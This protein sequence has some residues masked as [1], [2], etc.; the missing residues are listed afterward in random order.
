MRA[1]R[2]LLD[3]H[4]PSIEHGWCWRD[5]W[6]TGFD[7]AFGLL[8]KFAS[9]NAMGAKEVAH[10]FI[11]RECGRRTAIL[12]APNLDLR[13]SE[14]FDKARMA[15]ILRLDGEGLQHAFLLETLVN[16]KRVCGEMLRWC[17]Q[18]AKRGF[19]TPVFQ[20]DL[21]AACP[22]HGCKL[23][24]KCPHCH[25]RIPYR[26]T[27]ETF[28]SPFT[29]PSCKDDFA[30]ALRDP[31]T[32]SLR[33]RASSTAWITN[34][35]KLFTFEDKI[36]PVKLELN[37]RRRMLGIGEAAFAPGDWRRIETEYTG[38][39]TQALDDLAANAAGGQRALPFKQMSLTFKREAQ[40]AAKPRKERRRRTRPIP[41]P[42]TLK[43][44]S[45]L[46]KGWDDRLRASYQVYGA[47]RRHL[48]RHVVRK[49]HACSVVAARQ[50]WW[51]MEG[52]KTKAF[53][54][55]AEAFLRWR[56]YWEGCGVPRH[57]L[58]PMA[59]DPAGLAGWLAWGA[60][61]CPPGWAWEAEQWVSD[62]VL[63]RT[64][65]GSFREF[66]QIALRDHE[67]GKIFWNNHALTGKYECYWAIAGKDSPAAPVRLYEQLHSE[68]H[69]RTM[70]G[71]H[72]GRSHRALNQMQ[73]ACIVR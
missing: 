35:V 11:D 48:W 21:V 12:R 64:L 10:V 72:P 6:A 23:R 1:A 9:L 22:V 73:V 39:V 62:H 52:E 60:P 63:G 13:C 37:R 65:L 55:V 25:T 3:R 36:V 40:V 69:F 38:F 59:K 56:M 19:H 16:K 45:L 51:H 58:A 27:P 44:S 26:L 18:C 4:D 7:S 68:Y 67:R 49:H 29:C 61:I 54:P 30:P 5:D 24:S 70:L 42:G 32:R 66:L 47:V 17:P 33:L 31:K 15:S 14:F 57:L 43:N 34:L 20:L 53:C 41:V 2:I 28:K 8:A 50:M 46:K 71:G